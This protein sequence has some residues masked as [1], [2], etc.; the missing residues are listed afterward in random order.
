MCK[1]S[2]GEEPEEKKRRREGES[3]E[4]RRSTEKKDEI[5]KNAE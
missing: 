4:W 2:T 3:L 5:F 1:T